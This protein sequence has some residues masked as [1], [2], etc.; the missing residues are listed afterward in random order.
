M[1]K[2]PPPPFDR[3]ASRRFARN[4]LFHPPADPRIERPKIRG[5]RVVDFVLP[6]DLAPTTNFTGQS[7]FASQ[8]WRIHKLKKDVLLYMLAQHPR[9]STPLPGR[10]QVIAVRFSSAAIDDSAN[11]AKIAI[12]RL[13]VKNG[14]L[15]YITDDRFH[16]CNQRSWW[17]PA[18]KL[19]GFQYVAVYT[20][21]P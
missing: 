19:K 16:V 3:E 17:E 10:P 4:A 7:G 13:T 14:G 1:A 20:G 5:D 21:E 12:D 8:K 11:G 15:G 9:R 18:P 6:L 2:P